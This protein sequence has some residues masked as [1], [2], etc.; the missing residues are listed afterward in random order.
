MATHDVQALIDIM[1]TLPDIDR[2]PK[3]ETQIPGEVKVSIELVLKC[4]GVVTTCRSDVEKS[5]LTLNPFAES[6]KQPGYYQ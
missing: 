5:C 6:P 3:D 2:I 1:D 4:S